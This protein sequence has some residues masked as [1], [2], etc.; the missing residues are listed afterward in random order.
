MVNKTIK[1][2]VILPVYNVGPYIGRCIASL[3]DQT[4]SGLEFIFVDDCSGDDSMAAVEAWAGRDERVCILHNEC[5]RGAGYSR[6]RGIE[7]ARG[8]YISFVDSD[9]YLAPDFFGL[10]YAAAAAG[11][12]HDI[13]KGLRSIVDDAAGAAAPPDKKLNR[14]IRASLKE[15][16][17]LYTAFTYEHT[18]ALYH[19]RLFTDPGVRY[20]TSGN[21]EDITFLLRCCYQ[22]N[23]LVFEES[24][25]YYYVQRE[26][27]IVHGDPVKIANAQINA[28]IER[29]AF[30]SERGMDDAALQY[31]LERTNSCI[32][33]LQSAQKKGQARREDFDSIAARI[34]EVVGPV[35][36]A[37][38]ASRGF[39]R[40]QAVLR[41]R[42]SV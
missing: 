6:N 3:Q 40:L 24:A 39:P 15:G 17:P 18:C 30:L 12:G 32:L 7:A 21:S 20:G 35:P 26:G 5:N 14:L 27:S 13:S 28:M 33:R 37:L 22:T 11:G 31:I 38:K 41:G 29:I 8:E 34:R 1:I 2:T 23:D 36:G 16:R 10:L 19:R 25:L 4:L 9:D 42:N